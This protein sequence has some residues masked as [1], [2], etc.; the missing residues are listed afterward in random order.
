VVLKITT[1]SDFVITHISDAFRHDEVEPRTGYLVCN[2][3]A[4]CLQCIDVKNVVKPPTIRLTYEV[5][6]LIKIEANCRHYLVLRILNDFNNLSTGTRNDRV[7]QGSKILFD[8]NLKV[9]LAAID[10]YSY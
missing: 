10:L 7:I 5:I 6:S 9:L 4:G 2:G 8:R 1:Y 3:K